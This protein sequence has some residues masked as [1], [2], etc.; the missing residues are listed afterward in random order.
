MRAKIFGNFKNVYQMSKSTRDIVDG[1]PVKKVEQ[2][3]KVVHEKYFR[4]PNWN[5]VPKVEQKFFAIVPSCTVG[6]LGQQIKAQGSKNQNG[7]Q[8]RK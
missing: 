1:E 4:V 2:C 3:S 6:P 8:N 5:I 7:R